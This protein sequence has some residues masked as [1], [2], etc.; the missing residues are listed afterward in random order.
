VADNPWALLEGSAEAPRR[1]L[2]IPDIDAVIAAESDER[3][4]AIDEYRRLARPTH[5]LELE[6]ATLERYRRQA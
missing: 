5:D 1:R 2:G 3:R 6:L 4:R